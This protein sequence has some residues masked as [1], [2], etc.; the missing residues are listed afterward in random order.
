MKL[1]WL[2]IY[3]YRY[4]ERSESAMKMRGF[5]KLKNGRSAGLFILR[6]ASGME[7]S[8]TD[9]GATLVSLVVPDQKG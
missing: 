6:N 5:G 4:K 8:I 9:F 2:C 3:I 7:A 1:K